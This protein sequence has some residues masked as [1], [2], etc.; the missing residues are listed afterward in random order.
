VGEF[1]RFYDDLL[2]PFLLQKELFLLMNMGIDGLVLVFP[3]KTKTRT[4]MAKNTTS[5]K[6]NVLPVA[7]MTFSDTVR[8]LILTTDV[9]LSSKNVLG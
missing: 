8:Y 7:N 3:P 5:R 6:R 1:Y 4:K 2:R 9:Y